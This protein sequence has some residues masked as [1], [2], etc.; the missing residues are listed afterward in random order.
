MHILYVL[1]LYDLKLQNYACFACMYQ[2]FIYSNIEKQLSLLCK[3]VYK[4]VKET[5]L[6]LISIDIVKILK[7]YD[8]KLRNYTC[9]LKCAAKLL[10][11][12][13]DIQTAKLRLFCIYVLKI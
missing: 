6:L 4:K 7:I 5:K 9:F 2:K 1:E 11:E 12:L 3:Y 10:G 13:R 8:P